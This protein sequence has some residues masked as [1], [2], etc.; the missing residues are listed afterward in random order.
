MSQR[1]NESKVP[2]M[3]KRPTQQVLPNNENNVVNETTTTKTKE[4]NEKP[5]RHT[6]TA[7]WNL[8]QKARRRQH[9]KERRMAKKTKEIARQPDPMESESEEE[10]EE[11]E[12]G[13]GGGGGGGWGGANPQEETKAQGQVNKWKN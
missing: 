12:G 5:I 4:Q 1:A 3:N 13:G 8:K 11:E 9:C 10:E 2:Q 6:K 7:M